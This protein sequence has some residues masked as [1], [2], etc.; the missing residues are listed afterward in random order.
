MV[1]VL[2]CTHSHQVDRI[3]PF[4]LEIEFEQWRIP[5]P[6]SWKLYQLHTWMWLSFLHRSGLHDNTFDIG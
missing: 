1:Q 3:I 5:R 2:D 6:S 4:T